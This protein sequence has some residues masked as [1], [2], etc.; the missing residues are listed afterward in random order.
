[1]PSKLAVSS[2]NCPFQGPQFTIFVLYLFT[3]RHTSQLSVVFTVLPVLRKWV[4]YAWELYYLILLVSVLFNKNK[5]CISR[6]SVKISNCTGNS[7]STRRTSI[8]HST[9]ILKHAIEI[10]SNLQPWLTP[11]KKLSK[12]NFLFWNCQDCRLDGVFKSILCVLTAWNGNVLSFMQRSAE[13]A[14]HNGNFWF[15]Q[16]TWHI[17][18]IRIRPRAWMVLLSEWARSFDCMSKEFYSFF[19]LNFWP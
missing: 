1:M 4:Y 16:C 15:W 12:L 3:G 19:Y 7:E 2:Q 9:Y 10:T 18:D 17:V 8:V 13:Q 6:I 14:V 11:I 5:R